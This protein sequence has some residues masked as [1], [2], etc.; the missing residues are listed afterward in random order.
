MLHAAVEVQ[1]H[2]PAERIREASRSL[3]VMVGDGEVRIGV[4]RCGGGAA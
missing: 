2:D 1:I 4:D 3:E